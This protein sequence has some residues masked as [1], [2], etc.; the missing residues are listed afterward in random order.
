[1]AR[2]PDEGGAFVFDLV[3]DEVA[4]LEAPLAPSGADG[5]GDPYGAE[6]APGATLPGALGRRLRVLAPVAAVLAVVVG[7][8]FAVDG[9]R[10]GTRM[11]RMRDAR[12]GVADV[13]SP[14]RET[15]E[16]DGRVGPSGSA[17]EGSWNEVAVLGGLLAFQSGEDLV[18][19]DPATGDEAWRLRLGED[20]ECG[21]Q[22]SVGWDEAVTQE[23]VCLAGAGPDRV[24]VVVGPEGAASAERTLGAA[25]ARWY[26]AARPGP[27]GT[28]LRAERVGPEPPPGAN[29]GE[30]ISPGDCIGTVEVGRGVRLR[31]EDAVT[32]EE[33]WSVTVPFSPTRADQ[34]TNWYATHWD[35]SRN[36]MD[37]DDMV[38]DDGFGA[39]ITDHVVQLYGCG[40]ES[41]ITSDGVLLGTESEPGARSVASLRAGGYLL[42]EF[43]G[44]INSILYDADGRLV[45]EI[46]GY[47]LEPT[48]VDGSGPETLLASGELGGTVR[49]FARDGTPRWD[50]AIPGDMQV[51]LAQAGGAAI[52]QTG[53]GRVRALDLATG[54][55]RWTWD[56]AEP[57]D[58]FPNDLYVPRAFTDGESVLLAVETSSGGKG[59][60]ALDVVSGQVA[61]EQYGLDRS[62]ADNVARA[63]AGLVAVDGN[64]LEV[65]PDGV[66]GLG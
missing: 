41:A 19:L 3:D 8:G 57:D 63:G 24:A 20:P 42:H 55:E 56:P 52:F 5:E 23:L 37:L 33:R 45:G 64:L 15:W 14:L 40:V 2:D 7:T 61:W 25:D 65:A 38:D 58:A 39:R 35:G 49:S 60:V 44:A 17:G 50:V 4:D 9:V 13:T 1:M 18:A 59:L 43:D 36:V 16:W 62:A 46:N 51:F 29:D 48:A 12:G 28:V 34:C 53:E 27:D 6:P 11:E 10:D 66:R 47:V 31:A 22:G 30:C 21:P 26:G 32:G 54:T